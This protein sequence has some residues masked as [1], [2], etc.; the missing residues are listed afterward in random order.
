MPIAKKEDLPNNLQDIWDR[1]IMPV[2]TNIS[3]DQVI[4]SPENKEK[5]RQFIKEQE[6]RDKLYSYGLEPANRLLLYGASGTGKTFS[7]K[8]LSNLLQYTMVYVDI[9][10]SLTDNTVS[11]NISDIFK[12]GNYIAD[13]YDG[14]IIFFDEVDSIVWNR[15]ASSGEGGVARRATN[16]VFQG[17]DQMSHKAIFASA[18]NLLHRIDPAFERRFNM[19][20]MFKRPDMDMDECIRHFIFPKFIID[21]DVDDTTREIVKRRAKANAKLSYYEI[22]ELVKRAMKNAVLNDTNIVSTAEIYKDLATNMNFKIKVGT[23]TDNPE[24]FQNN[25]SYEPH[26]N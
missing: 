9:A 8:A 24:I 1:M 6:Y 26:Y 10:Q 16:A 2:D 20:M 15:D 11:K 5:Y 12:L 13:N 25:L 14:C 19:K 4:L 17:L 21:D 3:F 18:T 22:E 23:G 7:L